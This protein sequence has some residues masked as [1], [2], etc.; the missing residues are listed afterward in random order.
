[1]AGSFAATDYDNHDHLVHRKEGEKDGVECFLAVGHRTSS[2]LLWRT[3]QPTQTNPTSTIAAK[4]PCHEVCSIAPISAP[5][6]MSVTILQN[7][8]LSN[9]SAVLICSPHS[10][11]TRKAC[12]VPAYTSLQT[13]PQ[14]RASRSWRTEP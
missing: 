3:S 7:R 2:F 10:A 13:S 4:A 11:D 5:S 12:D 6:Q 1:M 14:P 9:T 8:A